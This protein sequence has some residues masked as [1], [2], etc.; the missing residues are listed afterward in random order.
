MVLIDR[1]SLLTGEV[2]SI[3]LFQKYHNTLCCPSRILHRHLSLI[4]GA[5]VS[6]RC[7]L[8]KRNDCF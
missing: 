5:I 3:G 2:S 1:Y 6:P 8:A 7:F 4:S